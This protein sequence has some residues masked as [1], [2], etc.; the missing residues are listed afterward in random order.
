MEKLHL[1]SRQKMLF[2][3][4]SVI[5]LQVLFLTTFFLTQK[6][7]AYS[8]DI[9]SYT[10]ACSSKGISPIVA[11]N[12][13]L[14]NQWLDGSRIND[15]ITLSANELWNYSIVNDI[16][17]SDAHPPLFFY[18]LHF[19]CGFFIGRF[20]WI[21]GIIVNSIAF[22]I[23]Q[24]FLYRLILFLTKSRFPALCSILF[25]GFTTAAVN[26]FTFVRMYTL[27]TALLLAHVFYSFRTASLLL[28]NKRAGKSLLLTATF[29]YF[30]ALTQYQ[31]I[32]FAFVL[33]LLICSLLFVKKKLLDSLVYGFSMCVSILLMILSFPDIWYQFGGQTALA[34]AA[35]FPFPLEFRISV[36]LIFNE[37]FGFNLPYG[38]TMLLFYLVWCLIFT[39]FLL[40]VICFL[41]R[42][43]IWFQ[44]IKSTV[45]NQLLLLKSHKPCLE[46]VYT[47]FL[48]ITFL[49]SLIVTCHSLKIYEF[50][51]FS[52]RYLF[53][54]YPYVLI[55]IVIVLFTIF[56]K[57]PLI[58]P[59]I[60][61]ILLVSSLLFGNR[62]YLFNYGIEGLPLKEISKDADLILIGNGLALPAD[63]SMEISGC[64]SFF[65]T[66]KDFLS[67]SL[68]EINA[69]QPE[70]RPLYLI[71][72][73]NSANNVYAGIDTTN[74]DLELIKS[75]PLSKTFEEVG[76]DSHCNF[77][78]LQ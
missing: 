14:I 24:I 47:V 58:V 5:S 44:N 26:Y 73:K 25:F 69:Y 16:L 15:S 77:Y 50:H 21:P 9:Y 78:R 36:R 75:L 53:N 30:S 31:S 46:T 37:L 7:G 62:I 33:T 35:S 63:L 49:I 57:Y 54:L 52:D 12:A 6:K 76:A 13:I 43:E 3:I 70:G 39:A 23:L 56:K 66:M 29:L 18:L 38:R 68:D 28:Q 45:L 22:F 48:F 32:A 40:S 51:P 61:S 60:L 10:T 72:E 19:F 2:V 20:S 34:N 41:F 11:D 55:I 4:L 65:F 8:D 27:M 74:E 64:H 1:L 71:Y 42:N 67:D 59:S 17:H